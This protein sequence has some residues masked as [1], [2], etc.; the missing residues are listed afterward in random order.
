MIRSI[1]HDQNY[2]PGRVTLHQQFFQKAD[3][4]R[5]I[6]PFGS[7]PSDR[8]LAPVVSTEDM[9]MSLAP[10]RVAGIR[11]CS[12]IFIQHAR[13]GGSRLRV[14]SSTKKS[15]KSSPRTFFSTLPAVLRLPPWPFYP[16]SGP[17]PA[18]VGD[19]DILYA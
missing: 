4:G 8:I 11:F 2:T 19:I 5:T 1:V 16:A 9:P 6:F 13:R 10:G 14:V 17:D 18:L 12:P 7:G 15:P 3:E